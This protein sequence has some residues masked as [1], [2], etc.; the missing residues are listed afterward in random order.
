MLRPTVLSMDRD[1]EPSTLCSMTFTSVASMAAPSA[2]YECN[3][4]F[5]RSGI[6]ADELDA[7]VDFDRLLVLNTIYRN[8]TIEVEEIDADSGDTVKVKKSKVTMG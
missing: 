1:T 4:R 6:L 2:A 8:I 3:C 7:V 5:S